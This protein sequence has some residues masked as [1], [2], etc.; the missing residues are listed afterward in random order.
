MAILTS[1]SLGLHLF[2]LNPEEGK[3]IEAFAR[4]RN[5]KGIGRVP[6][7]PAFTRTIVQGKS[8]VEFCV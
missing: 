4:Q 1:N 7:N 6:F 2:Y 5:I 3:A 8:I